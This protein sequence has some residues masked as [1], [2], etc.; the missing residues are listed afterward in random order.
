M[1]ISRRLREFRA[2]NRLT[3]AEL[4]NI[5]GIPARTIGSYERDEVAPGTKFYELMI[6]KFNININW[7]LTGIGTM[8][9]NQ[10]ID[11]DNNSISQLQDEIRFTNEEMDILINMLKSESS[12]DMLKKFVEIKQGRREALDILIANLKGIKAVF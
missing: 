8:F 5:L 7:L 3:S 9:I 4:A 6:E 2:K 10:D 11:D 12:R 1:T